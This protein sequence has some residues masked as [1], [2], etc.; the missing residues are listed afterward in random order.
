MT[1]A[2]RLRLIFELQRVQ[3]LLMAAPEDAEKAGDN[4]LA[5]DPQG[6]RYAA[7]S[8]LLQART[9][10]GAERLGEIIDQLKQDAK[11][12]HG[13]NRGASIATNDDRRQC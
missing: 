11:K 12:H 9:E 7:E 1:A 2:Q 10:I 8:G 4:L 13:G 6:N 5:H 3:K